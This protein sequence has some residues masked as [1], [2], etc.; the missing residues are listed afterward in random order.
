MYV[1]KYIYKIHEVLGTYTNKHIYIYEKYEY[2]YEHEPKQK[3]EITKSVT[4][5]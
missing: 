5:C 1:C 4:K 2:K 3:E